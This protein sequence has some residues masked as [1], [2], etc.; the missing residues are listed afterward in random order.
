M[1]KI[2]KKLIVKSYTIDYFTVKYDQIETIRMKASVQNELTSF[3]RFV[4]SYMW[5]R[6]YTLIIDFFLNLF[7]LLGVI[8]VELFGILL[9]LIL[10]KLL[11]YL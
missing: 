1:I 4:G 8:I 10:Y 7:V 3:I 11:T 5:L 6:F 2:L 9:T